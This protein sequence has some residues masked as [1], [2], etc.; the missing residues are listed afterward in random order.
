MEEQCFVDPTSS[1][2]LKAL[3]LVFLR[4][5]NHDLATYKEQW[6]RHGIRTAGH[7]TP[8]QLYVRGTLALH[9]STHTAPMDLFSNAWENSPPIQPVGPEEALEPSVDP[10]VAEI[11]AEHS[12]DELGVDTF[13]AVQQ[14]LN[15][16][17]G[18]E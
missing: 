15:E 12:S 9:S 5:I 3:H 4:R 8:L 7:Q 6:N 13:L 14:H 11:I 10:R 2:D 17:N 18:N 16:Y 1:L